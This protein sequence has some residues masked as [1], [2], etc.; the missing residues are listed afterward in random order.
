LG[1][2]CLGQPAALEAQFGKSVAKAVFCAGGA[3]AGLKLGDKLAQ[4]QAK[5][6][7]QMA[8]QLQKY[9]KA[10]QL[11]TALVL[12]KTGS[13]LAGTV[14]EKLSKHDLEARQKEMDAALAE[15][16]PVTRKYVLPDSKLEGTMT[17]ET[18]TTEGDK[19]CKVVVD[20]LANVEAGEPAMAKFCRK[21]PSEKYE[22]DIGV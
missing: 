21:P 10:F 8:S 14:Y 13:M 22:L 2:L 18:P 17:T 4:T 7:P 12:C 19:E 9:R 5:K 16:E 1:G 20:R 6:N 15:A 3:V 11:G